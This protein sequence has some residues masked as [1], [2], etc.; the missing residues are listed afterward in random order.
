MKRFRNLRRFEALVIFVL[1][2]VD[3]HRAIRDLIVA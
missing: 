2:A 3:L 1:S